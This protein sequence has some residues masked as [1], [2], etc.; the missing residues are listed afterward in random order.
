[1]NILPFSKLRRAIRLVYVKLQESSRHYSKMVRQKSRISMDLKF[2]F[3]NQKLSR[4]C[5]THKREEN[6]PKKINLVTFSLFF[7]FFFRHTSTNVTRNFNQ[8]VWIFYGITTAVF[9]SNHYA[10]SCLLVIF[11]YFFWHQDVWEVKNDLKYIF[12][13]K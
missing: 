2:H 6:L 1:M 4:E 7:F 11:D 10:I 5:R 8:N 13:G 12:R 3:N 9:I